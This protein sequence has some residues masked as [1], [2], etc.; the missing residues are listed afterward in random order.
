MLVQGCW[1]SDS[2]LAQIPHFYGNATLL[3]KCQEKHVD[4]VYGIMEL[5]DE[6]RNEIMGFLDSPSK[7]AAVADFVNNYPNMEIECTTN[8]PDGVGN[9]NESYAA[10][11]TLTRDDE[12]ESLEAVS[13]RYPDAKREEWW[14]ALGIADSKTLLALKKVVMDKESKSFTL[15]FSL[16]KPGAYTLTAWAICDSYLH[17]DKE[18]SFDIDIE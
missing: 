11:I 13:E 3:E 7:L 8:I 16:E 6:D 17:S 10:S 5:E 12:P 18:L 14:L 1:H 4:S 15:P 2:P 9:A